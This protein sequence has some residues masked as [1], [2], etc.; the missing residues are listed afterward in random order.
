MKKSGKYSSKVFSL[1]I[2]IILIS[3]S[4]GV[5]VAIPAFE[6]TIEFND[7]DIIITNVT[8]VEIKEIDNPLGGYV[9]E[10]VSEDD[11]VLNVTF[12][13]IPLTVVYFLID[14]EDNQTLVQQTEEL[15]YQTQKIQ[16]PYN[17][18]A[19]RI[20]IHDSAI[21]EKAS[22][23]LSDWELEEESE[24]VTV[25]TPSEESEFESRSENNTDSIVILLIV[26]ALVTVAIIVVRMRSK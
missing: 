8:K 11:T 21:Q 17:P 4:T 24:D 10:L 20:I 14:E 26:I 19:S 5:V 16:F 15:T 12:F 1:T 18:A 7:G 25:I 13:D 22:A 23:S 3:L 9:G 2:L 6:A